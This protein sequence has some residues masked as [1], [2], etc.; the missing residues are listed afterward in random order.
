MKIRVLENLYP[1]CELD[2]FPIPEYLLMK[3]VVI[4]TNVILWT[5]MCL[6]W[7]D[8]HK[9]LS[10][11]FPNDQPMML[12]NQAWEKDPFKVPDR[13]MEFNVAEYEKFTDMFSDSTLQL[14]FQKLPFVQF[15]WHQR[16]YP[17]LSEKAIKMLLFPTTNLYEARFYA[18]TPKNI[19]QD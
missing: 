1:H 6:H 17:R 10:R 11:Y 14:I 4:L 19:S 5:E 13:P 7:E 15:W 9:P 12:Q 2:S 16:R 8:L 18:S 3:S